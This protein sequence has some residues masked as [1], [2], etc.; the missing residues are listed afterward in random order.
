MKPKNFPAKKLAR[1]LAAKDRCDVRTFLVFVK[2]EQE[3]LIDQ[4][5]SCR[6]KKR[7]G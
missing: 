3:M 2:V 4:A 6:T 5:R 7:R 1:K